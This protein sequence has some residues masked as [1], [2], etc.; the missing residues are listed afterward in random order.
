MKG[1]KH[2]NKL[3]LERASKLL[4]NTD[5]T[6]KEL[7]EALGLS[8]GSIADLK[9]KKD[10]TP[11]AETVCILAN[12]FNVSADWL[13]GLSNIGTTDKATKELCNTLQLE[14]KERRKIMA[15]Q[16]SN[17][18][19]YLTEEELKEIEILKVSPEVRRAQKEQRERDKAK[20]Y[21]Y[22]LRSFY[23]RGKELLEND[24]KEAIR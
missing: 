17:I 9:N 22:Y 23:K 13:L 2:S 12:Y 3:F 1:Y 24:K 4:L 18:T 7:V 14:L 11:S 19:P 6:Q 5:K 20:R 16:R 15:R 10:K 8:N 21:L